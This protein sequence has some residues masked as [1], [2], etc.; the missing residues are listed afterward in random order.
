[1]RVTMTETRTAAPDG[2][3]DVV[4]VAGETHDLPDRLAL[5]YLDRGLAV[6]AEPIEEKAEA[7]AVENKALEAPEENKSDAAVE[8]PE[9]EEQLVAP[10][11]DTPPTTPKRRGGKGA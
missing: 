4:L 9:V 2:V 7:P 10:V 8:A 11:A 3:N 6:S 5:R 1:M